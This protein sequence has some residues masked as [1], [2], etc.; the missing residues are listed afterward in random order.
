MLC[1]VP[2]YWSLLCVLLS[3]PSAETDMLDGGDL[4]IG[5]DRREWRKAGTCVLRHHTAAHS[6]SQCPGRHRSKARWGGAE[7]GGTTRLEHRRHSGE[8]RWGRAEWGRNARITQALQPCMA[9]PTTAQT[10]NN[11]AQVRAH[12]DQGWKSH[13]G[14]RAEPKKG[15]SPSNITQAKNGTHRTYRQG[16]THNPQQAIKN[17]PRH[18]H[19]VTMPIHRPDV[20]AV[21]RCI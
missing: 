12:T 6:I 16:G 18:R 4:Y 2:L 7:R 8:V 11:S 15:H 19:T 9:P 14:G 20:W 17:T 13:S 3:T 21:H 5:E 1:Q 10:P